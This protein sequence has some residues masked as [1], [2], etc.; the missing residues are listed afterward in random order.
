MRLKRITTKEGE[1]YFVDAKTN[2][3]VY[4][5]PRYTSGT[6]QVMIS[7]PKCGEKAERGGYETWQILL[8]IFLFPIGLIALAKGKKPSVCG[9]CGYTWVA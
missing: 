7:C 6:S 2:K 3:R 8:S 4:V 5:N 9:K 1:V